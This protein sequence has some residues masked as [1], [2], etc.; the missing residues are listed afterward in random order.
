ME[1]FSTILV[2]ILFALGFI[3]L[4]KGAN[5]L[6]SGASS[7]AKKYGISDIVVGL[8]I[9]SFGTSAPELVVNVLA[10]F[11]GNTDIAIGNV[12]GSNIANILLILGVSAAIYPLTVQRNTLVA[13][14]PYSIV[15]I[16]LVG[17]LANS[18]FFFFE[19]ENPEL[20]RIDGIILLVFF[21][22]F[23]T[24]IFWL[25]KQGKKLTEEEKIQTMPIGKAV[26]FVIIG[27]FGLFL[28]GN[29]VVDGAVKI[30]QMLGMSES[31]IGLTV[32]AVG[33]SLP[34]LVTSAVAAYRKNSD[35][36]VGNVVGSNIFN[37]FWI[38]GV[39]AVINPLPFNIGNNF[40]AFVIILSS[41]LLLVVVL[42]NKKMLVNRLGGVVFLIAYFSYTYY[43]VMRG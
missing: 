18:R 20:S 1:L 17:F 6:V 40:D 11:R 23:M 42:F 7:I 5:F 8:T 28:G 12:F 14:I 29:W 9:V 10:S 38:L 22:L 13:E 19:R 27:I 34:E 35:I 32:V 33:T 26:F 43:L 2:Y 37:V 31:L 30:A 3:F 16:T 41:L 4:I 25:T 15:A 36:A 24:Y 39:S 21:V